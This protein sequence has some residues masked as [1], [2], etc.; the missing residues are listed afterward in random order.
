MR[1][2]INTKKKLIVGVTSLAMIV[3]AGTALAAENEFTAASERS[4]QIEQSAQV[5]P[6]VQSVTKAAYGEDPVVA[7][8]VQPQSGAKKEYLV[9]YKKEPRTFRAASIGATPNITHEF[10]SVPAVTVTASASEI[11]AIQADPN[12]AYIEENIIFHAVEDSSFTV[13]SA[14]SEVSQWDLQQMNA[15][16][17]WS[18]GYTGAGV[19]VAVL[20]T[21]I[22]AHSD[23]SIAGGYSAVD[24]TTSYADDEG[25]GTHVAGSIA[26]LRNNTGIVG[27]APNASLYGVKVLGADG[28]GN[29]ADILEGLDWAIQNGMDIINMSLGTETGSQLLEDMV[30]NAV[31][32]GI[33]VVA[34]SGN[35]G[36]ADG[37]GDTILYPARYANVIAVAAVDNN[38]IRGD[39]SA[40]GP[41]NEFS[42]PGVDVISTYLN[43]A[44][45]RASGTSQA[46]PHVSGLLALMKQ[47]DPSMTAAQLRNE[48]LKY[49]EDLGTPGRDAWYGFGLVSYKQLDVT[50]PAEVTGLAVTAK[51]TNSLTVEFTK[52][53]DADY[54]RANIYLNGALQGSTQGTQF[55]VVGLLPDTDNLIVVK[56]VDTSGNESVGTSIVGRTDAS[57]VVDITP[58]AEVTDLVIAAKTSSS[59]RIEFTKPSDPDYKKA[60]VYVDGSLK[61]STK[62]DYYEVTDLEEDTSYTIVVKTVDI[63]SNESV[64]V[65]VTGR[66]NGTPFDITTP[67]EVTGLAVTSKT[68]SSLTIGFTKPSDADYAKA[69]VYVNGTLNGSTA[70]ES[71][72]VVGLTDDTAYTIVV[73]TVDTT[74]NE[75][76][77]VT[78]T[79]RTD[80]V[81][82]PPVVDTTAPAEVTG[83]AV[84]SK[85]TSSLKIGFTKPND[86]D[87]AKSNVYVN[88]SLNGSTAGESY[89]VV[90]LTDD[91]AYTIV[92]KTVDTTGNESAGV[93]VTGRTDAVV[94]PPRTG[95]RGGGSGSGSSAGGGIVTIPTETP[96]APP[97]TPTEPVQLPDPTPTPKIVFKDVQNHWAEESIQWATKEGLVKGFEDGTFKPN[98]KVT[99]AQFLAMIIRL[100][101]PEFEA[102]SVATNENWVK[103]Y[104]DVAKTLNIP[105]FGDANGEITRLQVAE[106]VAATRGYNLKGDDLVKF[107]YANGYAEGSDP[108]K[109]TLASFRP[110]DQLTRAEAVQFL[111]NLADKFDGKLLKRP[112]RPS[113]VSQ[114]PEVPMQ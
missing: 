6:T 91:T 64:G 14:A 110:N 32:H 36:T 99:E 10:K 108:N 66:T 50:P 109:K 47:K 59:L 100:Y 2:A 23:L 81:V 78:V 75:S 98:A 1:K 73:K 4:V 56:T 112:D 82:V 85:T 79:G 107:M 95:G 8:V 70:G 101:N 94:T 55:E 44:F 16:T 106:I 41:K 86:A 21:G 71:Y 76:A 89:D 90:G 39:F 33:V 24:Y 7:P 15:T 65:T 37:S 53:S 5:D 114:L 11:Q 46:A 3:N 63:T 113:D 29:L 54:D 22:A 13:Q 83:L 49:T 84:T 105:T 25:H 31:S 80:A 103:K 96:V 111:K 40:T 67:A 9:V 77:G 34:S 28:K 97:T 26:A 104:Y 42:A 35:N 45:A 30:D 62:D 18:D 68:T 17:A 38:K 102:T 88:G 74:G 43:N 27:V 60:N 52:P 20:D 69:N 72:D 12:V 61:G 57:P 92:V 19:K 58:P 48:L 93:T 87:Y 51:T